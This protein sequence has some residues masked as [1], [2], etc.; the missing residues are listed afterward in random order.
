MD[1]REIM[2]RPSFN[3]MFSILL[4]I[5]IIAIIRPMCKGTDCVVAKPPP[6]K[7]WDSAV[8]RIGKDCFQFD[9]ITTKCTGKDEIE[10]FNDGFNHRK[11][12]I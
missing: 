10:S 6:S 9:L 5:G 7:E 12:I 8:Y 4:G 3:I 11:S 2:N 1:I